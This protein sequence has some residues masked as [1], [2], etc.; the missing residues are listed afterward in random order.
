M[1]KEQ[2]LE[3]LVSDFGEINQYT[4]DEKYE[5]YEM[6]KILIKVNEDKGSYEEIINLIINNS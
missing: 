3:K 6:L 5:F 2:Y 1:N 4:E